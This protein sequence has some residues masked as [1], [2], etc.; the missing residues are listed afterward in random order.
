MTLSNPSG[1]HF[2]PA[3]APIVLRRVPSEIPQ[4]GFIRPDSPD[5]DA[6]R[7]EL[8][9]VMPA[10]GLLSVVPRPAAEPEA[11]LAK[12]ADAMEDLDKHSCQLP[13]DQVKT[14]AVSDQ[15]SLFRHFG[16]FINR[17]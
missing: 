17:G 12:S 1:M 8:E 11:G 10:F 7:R 16:P 4:L 2:T 15:T 14:R 3:S 9:T 13:V 5:Y 6:Y